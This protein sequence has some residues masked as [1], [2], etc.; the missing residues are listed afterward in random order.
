MNQNK[1][2]QQPVI[3]QINQPNMMN[4][5][6]NP[7]MNERMFDNLYFNN[8]NEP[9]MNIYMP[10]YELNDLNQKGNFI[11]GKDIFLVFLRTWVFPSNRITII[12][13]YEDKISEVI[14]KYRDKS[15]DYAEN[16]EFIYNAKKLVHSY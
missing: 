3:S 12:C 11:K 10:N 2:Q 13:S 8:N 15:K 1:F 6:N 14:N 9:Q 16:R 4:M 5:N 7:L